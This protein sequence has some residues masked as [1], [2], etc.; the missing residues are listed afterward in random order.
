M[1]I[2]GMEIQCTDEPVSLVKR[3]CPDISKART[4]LG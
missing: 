4:D 3:Q 2:H 1:G